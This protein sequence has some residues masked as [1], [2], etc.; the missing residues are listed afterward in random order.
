MR[1]HLQDT[2]AFN[3]GILEK[4]AKDRSWY[5]RAESSDPYCKESNSELV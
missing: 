2:L 1:P 3:Q 5:T 4:D